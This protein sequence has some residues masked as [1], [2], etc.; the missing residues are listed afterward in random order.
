[1]SGISGGTPASSVQLPVQNLQSSFNTP[2]S[3][4][5]VAQN[6]NNVQSNYDFLDSSGGAFLGN[7]QSANKFSGF[8]DTDNSGQTTSSVG[9]TIIPS[10]NSFRLRQRDSVSLP[11]QDAASGPTR[12]LP[13]Y[14]GT[15]DLDVFFKKFEICIKNFNWTENEALSR[16][17]SDSIQVQANTLISSLPFNFEMTCANVKTKLYTFL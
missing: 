14:D 15:E 6:I 3:T 5:T 1:M 11:S 7:S 17:L 9:P 8:P 12:V 4:V 2:V 10:N 16:L 13:T